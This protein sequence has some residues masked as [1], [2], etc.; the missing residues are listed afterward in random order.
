[1][2]KKTW[3]SVESCHV[4]R[5]SSSSRIWVRG[6]ETLVGRVSEVSVMEGVGEVRKEN[7]LLLCRSRDLRIGWEVWRVRRE[8]WR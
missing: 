6:S 7:V 5:L 4:L 1:M 3:S 2:A 8:A